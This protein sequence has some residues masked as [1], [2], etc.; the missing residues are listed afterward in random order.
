MQLPLYSAVKKRVE[1]LS[2]TLDCFYP[3]MSLPFCILIPANNESLYID[4]CLQA[5][6][7]QDASGPVLVVVAANACTDDTVAKARAYTEG[8]AQKGWELICLDLPDGGKIG[9]LKAGEAVFPDPAVSRAYLD[10]DVICDPSLIRE[11][12]A[13]LDITQARYA[14]GTIAVTRGQSWATRAYA[15]IWRQVPFVKSGAVGAG[16]FA[17]N[18]AGRAR[19]SDWPQIISDDTFARLHFAPEERVETP[20]RYHW[21]MVEGLSALIRVRQRQNTGVDEIA[22]HWP[23]LLQNESKGGWGLPYFLR[24]CAGAPLAMAVYLTVHIAVRLRK[25]QADWSRGR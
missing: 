16:F 23:D 15:K 20:A 22:A 8:F 19:W 17:M 2:Y 14:T 11:V 6:A 9:A 24:V 10:A 7:A 4:A 25:P 18:G 13:A 1:T 21:P 3:L 5:L 12:R